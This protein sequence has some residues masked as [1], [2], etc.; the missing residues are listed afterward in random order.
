LG[1]TR[2]RRQSLLAHELGQTVPRAL[3]NA[4]IRTMHGGGPRPWDHE[5]QA[6]LWDG[7]RILEV[8]TN[9]AVRR[10]AEA[11]DATVEDAGGRLVLPGFVDAHMHFIHAGI[12]SLRP[13]LRGCKDLKECLH[14]VKA[15]L[16]AHPGSDAVTGEGWDESGWTERVWPTRKDLDVAAAKA[17]QTGRP[18]VL[19]RID[20]HIAIANTAALA[21][22]RK[23][24]DDDA[25]VHMDTGVLLEDASLYLNEALPAAP[26]VL[27]EALQRS[28]ALAHQLGV[29]SLGDY[30]QAPFREALLRAAEAG[31]LS[32]RVASSLYVQQLEE[33][34][35]AGF[36]TGRSAAG[37]AGAFLKDAGLKIFLDGSLGAHTA[38]L[39]EDYHGHP[40]VE[41][42][43]GKARAQPRGQLN[44][45]DEEVHRLVQRAHDAGVQVHAHAIGDAAIDQGLAAF[46]AAL[47]GASNGLRHRFEHY[48]IVHDDQLIRTARLGIVASS[49]PN[50]V[51]EWS[52]KGGM[53][54]DRL[55]ARFRLNNRFQTMKR[56]GI[57]VAFGSDGMPFGPL[58]GIQAAVDH[59]EESE[60][61]ETMEAVWHYTLE[62]AWSLHWEREVGSLAPGKLADLVV[63][64]DQGPPRD[65]RILQTIVDGKTRYAA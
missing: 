27:D 49:Q 40:S 6:I 32:V 9:E 56:A 30:S 39:R 25:L 58:V 57:R 60:R 47:G 10:Q 46:E 59:P 18:I 5:A 43:A 20:G 34:L 28:C 23:R 2:R 12:K 33:A 54:E 63:V 24:W 50:F 15:W 62:A 52:A 65:W 13:D 4:R 21:I 38:A 41:A 53:Y 31:P 17:G 16:E 64:E 8:G 55:G 1:L 45:S 29:T 61:M 48:E 3:V 22:I 19:R 11:M 26:E 35:A 37:R 42:P 36:R 44:W 7:P 51:G 14:R